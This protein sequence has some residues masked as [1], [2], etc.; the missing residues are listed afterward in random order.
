MKKKILLGIL[1]AIAVM[2]LFAVS[3]SA[4]TL[5]DDIY[6]DLTTGENGNTAAVSRSN[7]KTGCTLSTVVIP[8]TVEYE[9][10]TYTVTSIK[11][12][13]FEYNT[14]I[15]TLVIKPKLTRFPTCMLS[16]ATSLKK[17]YIDFSNVTEIGSRALTLATR[18]DSSPVSGQEFKLYTPESYGTDA[19]VEI[20]EINL[21]KIVSIGSGAFNNTSLKKVIIGA[22]CE[23]IGSQTF[24]YGDL[25]EITV[26]NNVNI[27][28]Y[29]C[30]DNYSLKK[31][32]LKSHQSIG[33]SAFAICKVVQEIHV[34]LSNCTYIG[35]SAFIFSTKYDAGNTLTQWYNLDG[36][37]IVDLSK[38][39]T[40]GSKSFGSS[41]IGGA[42]KD[43]DGNLVHGT[44]KVI[45]PTALKT[46]FTTSDSS[47]FRN[48]NITGKVYINFADDAT[49][50][51]Y[52]DTWALRG[53]YFEAIV[54]GD[55]ITQ[56]NGQPLNGTKTL[57]NVVFLADSVT[58]NDNIF[59]NCSSGINFYYKKIDTTATIAN[60][61]DILITSGTIATYG[62]CGY[63]V[64]LTPV[65][66]ENVTLNYVSHNYEDEVDQT[67]CPAGS[68]TVYTCA[69]CKDTYDVTTE[70]YKG[71]SHIFDRANGATVARVVFEGNDYF[72]EGII[73]VKC[74]HCDAE[75][76]DT[77]KV[78][79][80]FTSKGYSKS[81]DAFVFGIIANTDAI[82]LYNSL[83]GSDIKY[84]IVASQVR[85]DG[86]QLIKEDGKVQ[87]NTVLSADFTGT[88]Y[89]L[90]QIK[91][92]GI[93][94]LA[95]TTP[96]HC[97]AYIV[98]NASVYY[99]Y[100]DGS[101]GVVAT[102]ANQIS[103]SQIQ[104]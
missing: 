46:A 81:A 50:G 83:T 65:E 67:V 4:A 54:F 37:Q 23:S 11:D 35:A 72:S 94:E 44:T 92:A 25:E 38:V 74:L 70:D 14:S 6:Y 68:R 29:F 7:S 2:C 13:A 28:S 20:T 8:E 48:C 26:E 95:Y 19:D 36:E 103:H 1:I 42:S 27:P 97:C 63:V 64:D 88:Q 77:E 99:L 73:I 47:T 96:I 39:Q 49:E 60:K 100:D 98:D 66:G 71:D 31:I 51:I 82:D 22:T 80:L 78:G 41:N 89:S 84:G 85:T 34:D 18:D 57:K 101:K 9:G 21:D 79:A 56:I 30:G 104:D 58:L 32:N 87:D 76:E 40:L 17:V 91:V 52:I 59:N 102:V 33:D 90:L 43:A 75:Q 5:I 55:N 15:V 12:Y 10:E 24:R 3:A 62:A 69:G 86:K 16:G 45:F 53:N 93:S 61:V